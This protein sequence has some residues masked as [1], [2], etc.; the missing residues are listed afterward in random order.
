[1]LL[2][3]PILDNIYTKT[4]RR[5]RGE[6]KSGKQEIILKLDSNQL[7]AS[8][9]YLLHQKMMQKARENHERQLVKL[10]ERLK[11]LNCEQHYQYYQEMSNKRF[12]A[13]FE[14]EWNLSGLSF[15]L[16]QLLIKWECCD[17]QGNIKSGIDEIRAVDSHPG[18]SSRIYLTENGFIC[19]Q[20]LSTNFLS[21]PSDVTYCSIIDPSLGAHER[22]YK[23]SR[24]IPPG[25]VERFHIMVG[26]LRSSRFVLQF[27]F[28]ID[29]EKI[30][31]SKKF[32]VDIWNPRNSGLLDRYKDG[33][34]MERRLDKLNAE[35]VSSEDFELWRLTRA[36]E[37]NPNY[38]FIS[39]RDD[40][41]CEDRVNYFREKMLSSTDR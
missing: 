14:K 31:E 32:N 35:R 9:V 10:Q 28:F 5:F 4:Q 3:E 41:Y 23:M 12:E 37:K 8:N 11:T 40:S 17:K 26:A 27:R 15:P 19:K 36:K 20:H 24:K 30:V 2:N 25:D 1:M 7:C 16:G 21:V 6:I 29:D 13:D 39:P 34:E 38:P 33:D 18:Y 22:V